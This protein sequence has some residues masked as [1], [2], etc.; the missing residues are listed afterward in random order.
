M[1]LTY[2]IRIGTQ[3]ITTRGFDETDV[4]ELEGWIWDVVD[5]RGDETVIAETREKVKA[6]C[7]NKPVYT[8]NQ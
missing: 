6:I 2:L 8:K 3:A 7:A 5:S 4:K 1:C